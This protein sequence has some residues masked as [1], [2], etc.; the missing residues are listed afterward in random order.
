MDE[1]HRQSSS[2]RLGDRAPNGHPPE[3]I[4][5][6]ALTID[7]AAD[8]MAD[9]GFV[10][11]RTPPGVAVTDSCLMA[12]IRDAPTREHFDP[13]SVSYWVIDNGH[14]QTEIADRETRTPIS[15]PFSWGRIRLIDRLAM[16]NSFVTFGGWLSGERVATDALLL[17]FRSPA[18]ILRLPGHSQRSDRLSDDAIAFFG[19]LI[20]RMWSPPSDEQLV[21]S[22]PPEALYAAF[23]VYEGGRIN[24]SIPLREA[25]PDD[26]HVLLREL[27][28]TERHRPEA[29]VAGRELLSVLE[30]EQ[31][32][33]R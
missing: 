1:R 26:A 13:E 23:L 25:V 14:G 33:A 20:P 28:L 17:I 19:R 2:G 11:F 18:P 29:L 10:A 15:R 12:M 30:L 8:L 22:L 9:L 24:R 6:K 4:E 21:G 32:A 16:R 5:Q 31:P 27:E 7:E 3:S